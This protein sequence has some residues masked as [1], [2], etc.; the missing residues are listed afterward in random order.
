M[1]D[2]TKQIESLS[3]EMLARLSRR[4]KGRA[5]K[6][7]A[8][9]PIPPRPEA[10]HYPLSFAQQRLWFIDQYEPGSDA[11]NCFEG[12]RIEGRLN[13]A[14]LAQ[15]LGEIVRRHESLR[16]TFTTA[17]GEPAQ[18]IH[19]HRPLPLNVVELRAL[20]EDDR[21]RQAQRLAAEES[22]RPFD[23]AAGPL[24]RATLLRLGAAEHVVL[25]TMHHIVSDGWSMEVLVGEVAALYGAFT[26][27]EESP[28]A[29]LRVQYADYALWQRGRLEGKALE[30]QLA[31]WRAQLADA[32][33][34]LELP[35][36][37]PRPAAQGFRGGARSFTLRPETARALQQLS[38]REGATLYMTLLA[39]FQ[40]LLH[41]YT[42][43]T[44]ICVGT[45]LAGR[46]RVDLEPLIGFFV[47]TL[48]MRARIDASASFRQLL[49]QVRDTVLQAYAHQDVPF[50]QIVEQLQPDRNLSY[51]PVFQVVFALQNT[52]QSS[53]ELPGLSFS[54][55]SVESTT[56]KF[57]LTLIMRE[58]GEGLAGSLEYNS[59]LFEAETIERML[60]HWER[61]LEA[62]ATD[63]QAPLWNLDLLGERERRHLLSEWNDS[64]E[65]VP[66]LRVDQLFTQQARSTPD[67]VAVS[68]DDLQLTYAELDAR[69]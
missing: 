11:Y 2:I 12:I 36:D 4:L 67:A 61:L 57:D 7:P 1:S 8:A 27:G 5:K 26:R 60:G 18:L 17:D 37:H 3:P 43:Q 16:T 45:P 15:T 55:T 51:T 25:F 34:L 68:S 39:A 40:T 21:R 48:V 9:R 62:V 44:D 30:E 42:G 63:A 10:A 32:P 56:V 47:N 64:D 41:R 24:V 35:T 28:L 19:P 49:G 59:D 54:T 13:V 65:W 69:S 52:Q 6:S 38:R 14:A 66:G 22:R 31:Y 20:G 33:P 58:A 46:D 53:L 23:L 50:E 29:E